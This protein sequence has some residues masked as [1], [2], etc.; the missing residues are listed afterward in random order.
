METNLSGGK[1]QPE[2]RAPG[3]KDGVPPLRGQQEGDRWEQ[4]R[5]SGPSP[6]GGGVGGQWR[7]AKRNAGG[8]DGKEEIVGHME[9]SSAVGHRG[10]GWILEG[11]SASSGQKGDRIPNPRSLAGAGKIADGT[12]SFPR[13]SGLRIPL[14]LSPTE[15]H[16][17]DGD[18]E[19]E[20]YDA[21]PSRTRP[22][23]VPWVSSQALGPEGQCV[24]SAAPGRGS[25]WLTRPSWGTD[26]TVFGHNSRDGS[27]RKR[28][29]K[30]CVK[31]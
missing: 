12:R 5:A 16:V 18:P 22:G 9:P 29:A 7:E 14:P 4:R 20:G 27:H 13:I 15:T 3:G 1:V 11:G 26:E 10:G 21:G 19:A 28:S 24:L 31:K 25:R 2:D 8:R 23:G 30:L 6:G 17:G